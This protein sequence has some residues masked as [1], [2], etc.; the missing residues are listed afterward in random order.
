MMNIK[1]ARPCKIPAQSGVTLVEA[2]GALAVGA[3]VTAGLFGII[4]ESLD[5]IKAQQAASYQA[6]VADAAG[7]YISSRMSDLVKNTAPWSVTMQNLK[8]SGFLDPAFAAAN[9]YGQK[10]CLLLKTANTSKDIQA[11]LVTEGG[12]PIPAKQL[13]YVASLTQN[14]GSISMV[15]GSATAIGAYGTWKLELSDFGGVKCDTSA[16]VVNHLVTMVSWG[17]GGM[18]VGLGGGTSDFLYRSSTGNTQANTMKTTLYMDN[19][20]IT[21]A[22]RVA[23]GNF[24][25]T[26]SVHATGDVLAD[27]E[28]R[29]TRV[30]ATT[31]NA[32]GNITGRDIEASVSVTAPYVTAGTLLLGTIPA[33]DPSKPD[34]PRPCTS[35]ALG[36]YGRDNSSNEMYVCTASGW[37][38]VA[39]DYLRRTKSGNVAHNTMETDLYMGGKNI[40]DASSL[41]LE[42]VDPGSSC[43][44]TVP[45]GAI[46]RNKLKPDRFLICTRF[47]FFGSTVS[48]WL[49]VSVDQQVIPATGWNDKDTPAAVTPLEDFTYDHQEKGDAAKY[50]L[51]MAVGTCHRPYT[52][53]D[54]RGGCV[55][56]CQADDEDAVFGTTYCYSQRVAS[57]ERVTA[58]H[59]DNTL[60]TRSGWRGSCY[61]TG[62]DD[63][64]VAVSVL[65]VK[66]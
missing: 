65:C 55:A 18:G 2:L 58:V 10:P 60:V 39:A 23:A 22:N 33:A 20:E 17:G 42:L 44:D 4:N 41:F 61:Q 19:H 32:S 49:P 51:P 48:F 12:D 29:T 46:A 26:G 15:S 11:I 57:S 16:A 7:K 14:G 3:I 37:K 53:P 5:D 30:N 1:L 52:S 59:K 13:A 28:V 27:G 54:K 8:D 64:A 40:R 35:V 38:E 6:K 47:V 56:L 25:A 9:P 43:A 36:T 31:V 45:S 66:K 63:Q 62:P 34:A 21:G 50:S 24:D